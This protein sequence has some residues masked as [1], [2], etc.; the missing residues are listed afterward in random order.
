MTTLMVTSLDNL[1]M[2]AVQKNET[3]EK[4]IKINNQMDHVIASLTESFQKSNKWKT[5]GTHYTNPPANPRIANQTCQMVTSGATATNAKTWR[6][7]KE[8]HQTGATRENTMG[9]SQGNKKWI[10]NLQGKLAREFNHAIHLKPHLQCHL[11]N[12]LK[13]TFGCT[14]R[15]NL[16]TA[17]LLN[18]GANI[19]LLQTGAL[20]DHMKLQPAPNVPRNQKYH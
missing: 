10:P 16:S 9:G 20:A 8:G 2:A 3:A 7:Q 18:M 4:F 1:A 5:H 13:T 14:N 15:Q 17:A 11:V 19:S 12:S 6:T